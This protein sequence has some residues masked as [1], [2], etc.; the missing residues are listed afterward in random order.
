MPKDLVNSCEGKGLGNAVQ[1]ISD[2][3]TTFE[4]YCETI[5]QDNICTFTFSDVRLQL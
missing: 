1:W 2:S 5:R 4:I 3:F